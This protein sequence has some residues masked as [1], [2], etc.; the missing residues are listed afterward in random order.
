M[1]EFC[2]NAHESWKLYK[3][4]ILFQKCKCDL[5]SAFM[6]ITFDLYTISLYLLRRLP[7]YI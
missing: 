7:N 2:T 4:Q 1:V 6:N 5:K 3:K